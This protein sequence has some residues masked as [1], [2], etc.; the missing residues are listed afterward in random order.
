MFEIRDREQNQE[1]Q[2]KPLPQD[3][4]PQGRSEDEPPLDEEEN[5]DNW[6]ATFSDLH[7]GQKTLTPPPDTNSSNR[8]SHF[9]HLYSKRGI[10]GS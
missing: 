3:G 6:R 9:S 7:F 5:T 1:A 2:L 10:L 8:W 4:L